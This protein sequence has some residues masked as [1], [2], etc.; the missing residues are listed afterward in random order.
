M[1]APDLSMFADVL[2]IRRGAC[3]GIESRNAT[4]EAALWACHQ[5]ARTAFRK[6]FGGP[7]HCRAHQRRHIAR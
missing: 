3:K 4:S 6:G 7:A 5:T 1:L 2:G